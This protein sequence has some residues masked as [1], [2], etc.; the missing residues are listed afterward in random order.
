MSRNKHVIGLAALAMMFLAGCSD[1]HVKYPTDY[2]DTLFNGVE[3]FS[4]QNKSNIVENN[5]ENYYESVISTDTIYKNAVTQTLLAISTKAHEGKNV[6]SIMTDSDVYESVYAMADSD[7]ESGKNKSN[8]KARAKDDMMSSARSGSY[9]D[10]NLYY[11]SRFIRSLKEDFTLGDNDATPYKDGV[12]VTPFMEYGDVYD[13]NSTQYDY[14]FKNSLYESYQLNY[15]TSEYIYN[16]A[17]SSIG[18][19]N[20]RNVQVIALTERDDKTGNAKKLINAYVRDYIKGTG[21]DTTLVGTDPDFSVLEKLWKGITE[22]DVVNEISDDADTQADL[23]ERYASVLLTDKERTWLI[24][25][26]VII[27][28]DG[29]DTGSVTSIGSLTGKVMDEAEKVYDGLE[30]LNKMDSSLLSTYTGSGTYNV[31]TGVRKAI[32]EI[33]TK[34]LVTRGI[35]LKSDGLS[36]L[37]TTLKDRVFDNSMVT[38][39]SA[40]ETMKK[41]ENYDKTTEDSLTT[42]E[43]DGMRYVVNP[44]AMGENDNIVYYDASSKTYYIVRILDVVSASSLSTSNESSMYTTAQKELLAR[45]V[46]YTMSTTSTYQTDASVYWLRRTNINYYD[47]GFLDYMKSNY[48]DLFKTESSYDDEDKIDISDVDFKK[49]FEND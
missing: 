19:T 6:N 20:A 30:N 24:D 37:P 11:E 44:T 21:T 47:E 10:D 18:A 23:K 5:K 14:Y 8:L 2:T 49:I 34:S 45:K 43:K 39:K 3:D 12:L 32:D 28:S 1:Y 42:F 13:E 25:N 46:A 4:N 26:G 38:S 35:Y 7:I 16:K 9:S 17:Y 48:K 29:T 33:A 31:E 27:T 36:S 40:L 22:K 41:E 15:L